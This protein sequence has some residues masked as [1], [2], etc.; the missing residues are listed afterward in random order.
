MTRVWRK[1]E[2]KHIIW[3]CLTMAKKTIMC[4][5]SPT[6]PRLNASSPQPLLGTS[7]SDI[8]NLE[9]F[10]IEVRFIDLLDWLA[11][12]DDPRHVRKPQRN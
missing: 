2:P 3:S 6:P 1:K 9:C 12:N 10:G 4:S 5:S 7:P 11:D 8:V